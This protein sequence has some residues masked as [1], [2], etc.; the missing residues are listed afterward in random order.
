LH[1]MN[2]CFIQSIFVKTCTSHFIKALVGDLNAK[3]NFLLV[4]SFS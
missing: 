1:P 4:F 2:T 3:N